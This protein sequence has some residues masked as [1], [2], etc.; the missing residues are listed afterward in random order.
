MKK[1][2]TVLIVLAVIG[3]A[4][5]GYKSWRES[6]LYNNPA[7]AYGNGRITATEIAVASKLPGR[8]EYITVN[9][10][11]YVKKGQKLAQM[12]TNVL[13]AQLEQARAMV[14]V[15][16]AELLSSK[17]VVFQKKSTFD[18]TKRRYDRAKTL[19]ASKAVSQQNYETEESAYQGAYGELLAAEA[20]VKQ[21]E[22]AIAA[23]KADVARIQADIDDSS[24][25]A[26]LDGRVQYRIAQPGEIL[27]AGGRVLN[28]SDLTDVY[29]NFFV[30]EMQA[31]NINIGD[32]V[33]I[34]LDVLPDD[35]IPAKVSFVANVAQFTPKSVET[36]VERQKLMFR[37]KARI[38]PELLKK[39]LPIVKTG[40]PGVAW[41]RMDTTVPWPSE[42][43]YQEEKSGDAPTTPA[44]KTEK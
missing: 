35:P 40:L 32:E 4:F 1:I 34:M 31:G 43:Q 41:V 21:A 13:A 14:Q 2:I 16:E 24:I 42:L 26:P 8:L 11:D 29:M 9:E 22:S 6:R 30:S 15:R 12:Q 20:K 27:F 18:N 36:R 3:T 28:F 44:D 23:A 5:Y 37:V 17:A 25:V 7:F 10:G 38:D 39:H 33:R 19:Y